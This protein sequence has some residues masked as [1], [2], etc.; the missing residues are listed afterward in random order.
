MSSKD[1]SS[2]EPAYI[3][4]LIHLAPLLMEGRQE[5]AH[6]F[7]SFILATMHD[8]MLV[9]GIWLYRCASPEQTFSLSNTQCLS[10]SLLHHV[11]SQGTV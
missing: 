5:D 2:L 6:E 9:V 4:D 8:E 3:Y 10:G 11:S 7:L 1:G